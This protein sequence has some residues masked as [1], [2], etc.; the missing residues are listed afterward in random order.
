[1]KFSLTVIGSGSG[2]PLPNRYSSAQVLNIHERFILIDCGEGA[3]INLRRF[4]INFNRIETILISHLHGDH[5]FGLPGLLNT[6]NQL[7]RTKDL[8]IIAHKKLKNILDV[9]FNATANEI[10]YKIIF[11]PVE[12]LSIE[13]SLALIIHYFLLPF[14]TSHSYDRIF[15]KRNRSGK[16]YQNLL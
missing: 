1:M 7:G 13:D 5:F 4:G 6:F 14:K 10:K 15:N 8:N 12:D 2:T 9:L 11:H 16:N 3:Q